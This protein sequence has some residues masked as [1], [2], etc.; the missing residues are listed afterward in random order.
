MTALADLMGA[1]ADTIRDTLSTSDFPVQVEPKMIFNPTPLSVDIYPG[2]VARDTETAGMG[3]L[4]GAYVFTVRARINKDDTDATQEVL[5]AMLDDEDPLCLA[6]ALM[7][8][9]TLGGAAADVFV[10]ESSGL[11]E[12]DPYVGVTWSVLVVNV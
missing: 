1:M 3:E 12:F 5:F 4:A 10:S 7:A 11:F 8:D 6:A 9:P 2:F